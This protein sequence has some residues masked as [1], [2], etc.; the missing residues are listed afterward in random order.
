M[1]NAER[2]LKAQKEGSHSR[3]NENPIQDYEGVYVS[4]SGQ[5]LAMTLELHPAEQSDFE[6][7]FEAKREALGPH[8][9]AKWGWDDA[10]QRGIHRTRWGERPWSII[11]LDAQSIGTVSV[12][13]TASRIRFGEFYLLPRRQGQGIGSQVLAKTLARADV[14]SVPVELEYLKWNPVGSLYARHGFVIVDET[15]VHYRLVRL[16]QSVPSSPLAGL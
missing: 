15:D 11:R 4:T 12:D 3:R 5:P 1:R 8:V 7:A 10:Y 16:P 14:L 2:P 6:F 9:E 13:E